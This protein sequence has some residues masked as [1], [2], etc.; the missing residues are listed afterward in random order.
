MDWD[1]QYGV[2]TNNSQETD[3]LVN[4]IRTDRSLEVW[5]GDKS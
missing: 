1:N 4:S 3:L 2:Q 5:N